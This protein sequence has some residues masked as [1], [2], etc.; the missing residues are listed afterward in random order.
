MARHIGTKKRAGHA[1]SAGSRFRHTNDLG[2]RIHAKNASGKSVSRREQKSTTRG[3]S[4]G[5][6]D[7]TTLKVI[8]T[9]KAGLPYKSIETFHEYTE[10]PVQ[11][12]AEAVQ[13]P[14]R[15]LVRRK[16]TGKFQPD[17]SERLLR[18]STVFEKAV[19]LF[20][21]ERDAAMRWLTTPQ[22]ALDNA[23]PFD[24]ARTELGAREVEDLIGRLEH[25][26]Y[27]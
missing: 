11:T 24:F 7:V 1:G 2:S 25:G 26:V 10:L 8:E 9:I 13:I 6:K 21:G 20:E 18:M 22:P 3:S 4:I 15:T 12:I 27:T 16:S 14:P 19:E 5:L 17:E 23:T